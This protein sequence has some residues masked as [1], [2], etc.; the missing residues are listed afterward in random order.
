MTAARRAANRAA[1]SSRRGIETYFSGAT[2][3][4][5][6]T[7]ETLTPSGW[8]KRRYA[9]APNADSDASAKT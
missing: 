1:H 4:F 7:N 6:M 8:V 3:V 2:L 9:M 5:E